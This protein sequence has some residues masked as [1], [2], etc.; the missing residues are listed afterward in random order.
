MHEIF[1][2]HLL[3]ELEYVGLLGIEVAHYGLDQVSLVLHL[4]STGVDRCLRGSDCHEVGVTAIC[5]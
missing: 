3:L 1:G 5:A 2:I 4:I